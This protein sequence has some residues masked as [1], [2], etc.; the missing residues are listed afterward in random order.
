MAINKTL[1][2]I[3]LPRV[4]SS[5]LGPKMTEL[6]QMHPKHLFSQPVLSSWP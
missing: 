5:P 1:P 4:Q 6:P 3:A 2:D